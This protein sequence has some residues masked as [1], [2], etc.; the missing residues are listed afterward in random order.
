[1]TFQK[2]VEGKFCRTLSRSLSPVHVHSSK[3]PAAKD[4]SLS[5]KKSNKTQCLKAIPH[6]EEVI[7]CSQG[8]FSSSRKMFN[9]QPST[10]KK[11]HSFRNSNL[12][13]FV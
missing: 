11:E 13:R 8:N 2:Q 4:T 6:I 1:M 9:L 10:S 12:T 7:T 5:Q 3:T